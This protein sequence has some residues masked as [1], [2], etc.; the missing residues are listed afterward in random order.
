MTGFLDLC[1]Y[2]QI[3]YLG[4]GTIYLRKKIGAKASQT[5]KANNAKRD[6]KR[7]LLLYS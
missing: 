3:G 2:R 1:I 5:T 6:S 7:D 4:Y